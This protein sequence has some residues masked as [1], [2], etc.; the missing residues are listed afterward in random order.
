MSCNAKA[1]CRAACEPLTVLGVPRSRPTSTALDLSVSRLC[2]LREQRQAFIQ[3]QSFCTNYGHN[4]GLEGLGPLRTSIF[5][6]KLPVTDQ[7]VLLLKSKQSDGH[8]RLHV[9]CHLAILELGCLA[10]Q[11]SMPSTSHWKPSSAA[12]ELVDPCTTES[13]VIHIGRCAL[14]LLLAVP[15]CSVSAQSKL[16]LGG[17]A[18]C[19]RSATRNA[20]LQMWGFRG[21]YTWACTT[22]ILR[23]C[24]PDQ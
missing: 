17:L 13:A 8:L 1:W 24:L 15:S 2:T 3:G 9:T 23:S 11:M 20:W 10:R 4:K 12:S 14:C 5:V 21:S 6:K 22:T 7:T 16:G 18:L 19:T